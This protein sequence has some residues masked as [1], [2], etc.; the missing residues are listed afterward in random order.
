VT[1]GVELRTDQITVP[2]ALSAVSD[3]APQRGA[4]ID[5]DDPGCGEGNGVPNSVE[6]TCGHLLTTGAEGDIVMSVGSCDDAGPCTT[7]GG[8]TA[9]VVTVNADIQHP[10]GQHS[11]L[12]LSCD[13]VLCGG[14]GVPKRPV[15]Y[16]F[17]NS[18]DL[19]E[20]AGACPRK[21]D[22]GSLEVCVDYVSSMRSDGDLY[23]FVL[24]DHDVR[25]SH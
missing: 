3:N 7:S 13:K 1:S 2:I 15:I 16:T 23:L 25:F 4:T 11:T 8:F 19:T 6:P 20:T 14:T 9:L 22:L 18:G 10:Q 17:D 12:I 5:L 24:F 21:S